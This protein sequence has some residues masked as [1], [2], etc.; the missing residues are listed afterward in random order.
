MRAQRGYGMGGRLETSGGSSCDLGALVAN[1][2]H[3]LIL[4]LGHD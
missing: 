3:M 4:Y 2:V 1:G